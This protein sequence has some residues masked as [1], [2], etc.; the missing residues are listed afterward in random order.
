MAARI[1]ILGGTFDPPH[2][3]HLVLAEYAADSLGLEH[4]LFV[5]AA[6]PPHKRGRM[7]TPVE[8][9]LAMLALAI[10]RDARFIL[11]RIDVDRPGPHYSNDMVRVVRQQF[12]DAELFFVMGG[13]SL[14][15]LP[16]WDHPDVLI[17]LCK[18]AVMRRPPHENIYPAMHEDVLPGLQDRVYMV[19]A[20]Q[21][22]ISSTDIADRLRSGRSVRYLMPETVQAYI[23]AQ[24]LY[25]E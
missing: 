11:S 18:L 19:D 2:I 9:R 6:D 24:L 1:G 25:K 5:P 17:Q 23:N 21:L 22:E 13:D 4:V 12:P 7:K 8:H 20:P 14:K 3:G 15:D 10:S 16:N